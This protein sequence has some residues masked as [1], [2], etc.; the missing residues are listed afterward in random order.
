LLA[1]SFSLGTDVSLTSIEL[2]I[3]GVDR[4]IGKQSEIEKDGVGT[5]SEEQSRD[6]GAALHMDHSQ[7]TGE[8]A[9]SGSSKEQPV[10]EKERER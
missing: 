5:H 2:Y 10:R 1:R 6:G 9:L 3:C 4:E 7:K 8:V